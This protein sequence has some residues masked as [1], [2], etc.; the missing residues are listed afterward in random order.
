MEK[1]EQK[2][3]QK[4]WKSPGGGAGEKVRA[5]ERMV[6]QG[7]EVRKEKERKRCYD[8]EEMG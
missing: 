4:E 5:R 1:G 6:V 3:R 7:I 8:T 2:G